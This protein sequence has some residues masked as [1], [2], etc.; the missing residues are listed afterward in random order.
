MKS[1]TALTP[2]GDMP[3]FLSIIRNNDGSVAVTVRGPARHGEIEGRCYP[4]T[5]ECG[6][7]ILTGDEWARIVSRIIDELTNG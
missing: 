3:P 6:T 5:G 2:L 1:I 4:V 7:I